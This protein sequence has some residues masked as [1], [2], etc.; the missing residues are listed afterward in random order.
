VS[1]LSSCDFAPVPPAR[2]DLRS[3]VHRCLPGW[4]WQDIPVEPYKDETEPWRGVVRMSLAGQRGERTAFH[5][6]Y[7]EIA[8]GGY[9]SLERHQHEHV[10]I[11]LHGRGEVQLGSKVEAIG[12]GDLVYVAPQEWH[13]FRNP[14]GEAALGFLC[15]VDA[16]RDRPELA[17]PPGASVTTESSRR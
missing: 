7:F 14:A 12:P 8:P 2:E 9:T 5:V 15:I 13:Q 3:R 4:R 10:V 6:R 1:Q 16:V 17:A 11:V